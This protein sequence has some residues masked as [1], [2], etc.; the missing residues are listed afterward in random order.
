MHAPEE[1]DGPPAGAVRAAM[2]DERRADS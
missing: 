1:G 2:R